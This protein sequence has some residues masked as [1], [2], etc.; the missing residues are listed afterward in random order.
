MDLS[1]LLGL[2]YGNSPVLVEGRRA[3]LIFLWSAYRGGHRPFL[4]KVL[5]WFFLIFSYIPQTFQWFYVLPEI[6]FE[7][8]LGYLQ[9]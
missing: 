9:R 5:L 3:V 6:R 1:N 8:F 4:Q 2:V 7:N